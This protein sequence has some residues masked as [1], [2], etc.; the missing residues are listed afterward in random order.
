MEYFV[1]EPHRVQLARLQEELGTVAAVHYPVIRFSEA[2]NFC[3]VRENHIPRRGEERPVKLAFLSDFSPDME[4]H[5][6]EVA[7][8][9]C[10][11]RKNSSAKILFH[12]TSPDECDY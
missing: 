12:C 6:A 11:D 3:L 9:L 10:A 4:F 5:Y 2:M 7:D 8:F 1:Y